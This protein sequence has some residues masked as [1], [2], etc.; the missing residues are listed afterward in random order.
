MREITI[1]DEL[2]SHLVQSAPENAV[3]VLLEFEV[4][5]DDSDPAGGVNTF[6]FTATDVNGK[7]ETYFPEDAITTYKLSKMSRELRVVMRESSG[8]AWTK[9]AFSVDFRTKKFNVDFEY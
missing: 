1:Y 9:M 5:V 2:S 7:K 3:H 8:S 6:I 4:K